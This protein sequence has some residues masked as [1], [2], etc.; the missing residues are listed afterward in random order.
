MWIR[1]ISFGANWWS[2]H[3]QDLADPFCFRRKAAW[4]N[5]AGLMYGR[6]LRLCWVF[7]GQIR[8]N[9]NSG[10]DPE[11]PSRALRRTFESAG[12]TRMNGRTH[13]LL[14]RAAEHSQPA[15]RFLVT[16]KPESHGQ[17]NFTSR[18]WKSTNAEPVSVSLRGSRY[19]AMLLLGHGDWIRT[20]LGFWSISSNE[21][22][23]ALVDH[24][25]EASR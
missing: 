13:L 21:D 1:L 7:P 11:Y 10:F 22:R 6:R 12:A 16:V 25:A 8:F 9:S 23:L 17:I 14:A 2:T 4:F 19:E 3:S 15:D 20:D 5:S 24:P 18:N